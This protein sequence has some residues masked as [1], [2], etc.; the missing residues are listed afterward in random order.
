VAAELSAAVTEAMQSLAMGGARFEI[1]LRPVEEGCASGLEGVE[2]LVTANAS[3]PLRP[4]ARV[5]SG[6]EL[7]RIGLAIQ[8][9]TSRNASTPT[10]IFDEVDVGIGGRVAEI[11]GRMLHQLGVDRQVLCVTHL[12]QVAARADAQWNIAKE[13]R[14]G[15]TLSRVR[16]LDDGERIDEIA[17]MLG[18]VNITDTT[19]R[20]A[21]EMLGLPA[22]A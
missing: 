22:P 16:R 11:V 21:A 2:F 8:V 3:Q 9:I 12:P 1:A 19:R 20:H 15:E 14:D 10:L 7:S 18:G 4:L 17:R 13:T 6:G 5:A